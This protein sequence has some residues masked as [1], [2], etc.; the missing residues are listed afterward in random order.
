MQLSIIIPALN[1]ADEIV[2][3]LS[4][5]QN[6]RS[7]GA[8]VILVDG[9]SSDTTLQLAAPLVDRVLTSA[10]GRAIQ[11]NAGAAIATAPVLLFL[12]ADSIL[13]TDAQQHIQRAVKDGYAWGRFDVDIR[14]QHIMF[15]VIGWFMNQRSRLTGVATGDQALFVTRD[16]FNQVGGFPEQPLMED[17]EMCARLKRAAKKTHRGRPACLTSRVSTSGR[18]WERHGIWRTMLLMWCLRYQYWRGAPAAQ[19]HAAYRGK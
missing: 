6:M 5:L 10:K 15:H 11:M 13:P 17:I 4:A 3:T 19:L 14:G 1:E 16:A 2:A 8:E 18:R 12:H 9:G 7:A